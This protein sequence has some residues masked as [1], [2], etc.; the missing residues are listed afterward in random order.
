MKTKQDR[1]RITMGGVK[2]F[3]FALLL[4]LAGCGGQDVPNGEKPDEPVVEE[5]GDIQLSDTE[6]RLEVADWKP[7]QESR[8]VLFDQENF[9]EGNEENTLPGGNFTL[10]AYTSD[11]QTFLKG[12]R[13]WYFADTDTPEWR[14][15]SD[16]GGKVTFPTY[17][18][19][20]SGTVDFF[21][22]MPYEDYRNKAGNRED[23]VTIGDYDSE[24]GQQ[25]SCKLPQTDESDHMEFIYAY[26]QD[27][28]KA[29]N[30]LKLQFKHPFA[31][32]QFKWGTGSSRMTINSLKLDSMYFAGTFSTETSD[33]TE[34]SEW[35]PSGSP[36]AYE[37][38]VSKRIPTEVNYNTVFAGPYLVM[39][40]VLDKIT[41]TLNTSQT[42]EATGTD[43]APVSLS[44]E[45]GASWLP[46]HIYTY[47]LIA[48]DRNEEIYFIVTVEDWIVIKHRNEVE[49]E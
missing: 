24:N 35:E 37:A 15:R 41:L 36:G 46:G 13:G 33:S 21:A 27:K 3:A 49:V 45:Q 44:T 43:S 19:P 1:H 8:A 9:L 29:N 6:I 25:F 30:P 4:S 32:V 10:H 16:I 23:Y 14:F 12:A 18:W 42:D 31:L 2:T 34:T 28:T 7:L 11:G 40:Q 5:S 17:Y 26:E 47:T 48:G 38:T 22:Y 20:N 39:P